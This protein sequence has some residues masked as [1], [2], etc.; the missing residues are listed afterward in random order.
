M[1][2][3]PGVKINFAGTIRVV[4]PLNLAALQMLQDRLAN[5]TGGLD[6]ESVNVVIDACYYSL[7]RNYPDI[8]KEEI[9]ED[10]DVGNMQEIM[11]AI[12]D[13]SGLKRK[14][15]E[16]KDLLGEPTATSL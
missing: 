15:Q 8:T 10:V 16:G 12:M 11:E 9:A 14:E 13:I 1:V 4:P 3:I 2:K 7:R 5:F 6:I